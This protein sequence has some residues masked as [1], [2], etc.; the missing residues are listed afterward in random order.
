MLV[1]GA[2]LGMLS[3]P[4]T[5]VAMNKVDERD[6]GLASSLRNVGQQVG[7]AIGLALL[8]T[9]AWTVV[10]NTTRSSAAAAKAGHPLAGTAAQVQAAITDHALSVGFGR[11][12]EVAVLRPQPR[13]VEDLGAG[14]GGELVAESDGRL[15]LD[16]ERKVGLAT[17]GVGRKGEEQLGW[18]ARQGV[19]DQ[20]RHIEGS[21]AP[22]QADDLVVPVADGVQVV[23]LQDDMVE[24]RHGRSPVLLRPRSTAV[25]S[26]SAG[27]SSLATGWSWLV[28]A[29]VMLPGL[30]NPKRMSDSGGM[31]SR[32]EDLSRADADT[33]WLDGRVVARV[34]ACRSSSS[35]CC[36]SPIWHSI[37]VRAVGILVRVTPTQVR[38]P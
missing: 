26:R 13:L 28:M 37:P 4:L 19:P 36:R 34:A 30:M 24:Q 31:E 20:V 32:I 3:M 18:L 6:A 21:R 8:G 10:A 16:P 2:G 33:T 11:G 29:W 5:L 14:C 23:D 7:G 9:V 1:T 15:V 25:V 38:L 35:A 12:F 22:G 27:M 17:I